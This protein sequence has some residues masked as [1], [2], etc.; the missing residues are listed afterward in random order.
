MAGKTP[1]SA[2][3]NWENKLGG[4]MQMTMILYIKLAFSV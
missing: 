3:A 1:L 4:E 2:I